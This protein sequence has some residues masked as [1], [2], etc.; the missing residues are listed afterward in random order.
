MK[1][2]AFVLAVLLLATP[3]MAVIVITPVDEG[4]GVVRIDYDASG[5]GQL[6]RAFALD[7]TVSAGTIDDI[8]DYFVGEGAGFGIFPG[9]IDIND[10]TGEVD[11]NGTPEA[12]PCQLPSDTQPGLGTTGVTI[13]MGSLYTGAAPGNSGTL[14]KVTVT[15]SCN[16]T[17]NGNIGRGKVVNEDKTEATTNLPQTIPVV[18]GAA[19]TVPN[20][21]TMTTANAKAAIINAGYVLGN[22]T[23]AYVDPPGIVQNQ[24]PAAGTQP[25][26]GS[27][28]DIQYSLPACWA[29]DGQCQGATDVDDLN[30]TLADFQIFG[31]AFSIGSIP[32]A[33]PCADYNHDGVITLGDFQIFG[34]SFSVGNV[35]GGCTPPGDPYN[36]YGP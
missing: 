29:W 23:Y 15:A 22:L 18:V 33:N 36:V 8:S 10:T 14:C 27:A 6:P 34:P 16:L 28:V 30:I 1:K 25:A 4:S 11:S 31:P 35:P 9:T 7:I 17:V 5:H 26:C 3:A 2:I 21:V 24:N 12:D 20:V 32:P 19:C 13:E